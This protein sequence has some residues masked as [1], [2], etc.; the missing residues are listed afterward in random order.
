MEPY[1]NKV[2]DRIFGIDEHI[3]Y[4]GIV[5]MG[6]HVILSR[7]RS[8]IKS[9]TPSELDWNFVS[10]APRI[11]IESAQ[12]LEGYCGRL[13]I[14]TIRYRRV[15][16]SLYQAGKHVVIVSFEPTVQTPFMKKLSQELSRILHLEQD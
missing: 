8:S 12:R 1:W 14:M 4:V 7:M 13:E 6:Y 15:M 3:R 9:M 11:M 5:D 16:L 10:M 2:A